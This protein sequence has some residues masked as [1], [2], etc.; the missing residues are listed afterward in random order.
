MLVDQHRL[1]GSS[2]SELWY[3][4]QYSESDVMRSWDIMLRRVG[5]KWNVIGLDLKNE[6]HGAATWGYDQSN[7]DWNKAAER[8]IN[9]IASSFSSFRGLFFVEGVGENARTSAP[10]NV[11]H[12]WGGNLEGVRDYPVDVGGLN[13]RVVYSPHVYGPG[14]VSESID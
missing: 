1:S 6:P 5:S 4:G 8:I 3:D 9:H 12:F 14:E 13:N 7:T 10:S 2:I 11:G